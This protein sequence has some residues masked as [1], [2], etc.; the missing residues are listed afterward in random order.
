MTRS[1]PAA[2]AV[3][4][5]EEPRHD[6]KLRSAILALVVVVV[7]LWVAEAPEIRGEGVDIELIVSKLPKAVRANFI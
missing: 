5:Y 6:L 7:A 3:Y 4:R 1:R 2:V